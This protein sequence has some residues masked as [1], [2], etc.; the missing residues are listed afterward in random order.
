MAGT[1][2]KSDGDG[3]GDGDGEGDGDG[4][5]K[6]DRR[7]SLKLRRANSINDAY[8]SSPLPYT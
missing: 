3:G 6:E 2:K 1:D 5:V 8:T 7:G 4:C